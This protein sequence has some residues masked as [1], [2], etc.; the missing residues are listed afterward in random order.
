MAPR[1]S[2]LTAKHAQQLSAVTVTV[3]EQLIAPDDGKQKRQA[4]ADESEP[5]KE[6]VDK[7]HR[8]IKDGPQP[9][10]VI[11]M[12]LLFHALTS[13][14]IA[15]AG[16]SRAQVPQPTHKSS[17]TSAKLPAWMRIAPRGQTSTHVPQATQDALCTTA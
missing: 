3:A 16:H 5:G 4:E 12:M 11:P 14:V 10:I 1:K 9:K 2:D 13:T 15:E 17:L 7:A 6:N 8:E